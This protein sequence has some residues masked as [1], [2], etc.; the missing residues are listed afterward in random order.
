MPNNSEIKKKVKR[1]RRSRDLTLITK[2]IQGSR[3]NQINIT[4]NSQKNKI[5]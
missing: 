1:G 4:Q 2:I 5:N 3:L